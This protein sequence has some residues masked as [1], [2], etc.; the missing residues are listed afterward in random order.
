MDGHSFSQMDIHSQ[1]FM[2]FIPE[3]LHYVV[4]DNVLISKTINYPVKTKFYD[5]S[6]MYQIDLTSLV[7]L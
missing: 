6:V 5:K 4:F 3:P 1:I 7:L 2:L